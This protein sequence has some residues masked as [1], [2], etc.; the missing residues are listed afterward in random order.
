MLKEIL[1][2]WWLFPL[3]VLYDFLYILWYWA[4]ERERAWLGGFASIA[5][6]GV[7]MTGLLEA[8]DNRWTLVPYMLGLFMGSVWGIKLKAYW[9]NRNSTQP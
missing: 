6:V 8:V 3:G 9:N 1:E 2:G 4:A 5:V 7:G